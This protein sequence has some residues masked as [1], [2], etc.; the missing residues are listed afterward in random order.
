MLV[1]QRAPGFASSLLREIPVL[2][3][4]AAINQTVHREHLVANALAASNRDTAQRLGG[5][6]FRRPPLL[7][8]I[9][10]EVPLTVVDPGG[11]KKPDSF[12]RDVAE[13]YLRQAAVS[14]RPAQ[15]LAE[16]NGVPAATVHRWIREAKAAECC[17][18]QRTARRTDPSTHLATI[19]RQVPL[20]E[21]GIRVQPRT[22]RQGAPTSESRQRPQGPWRVSALLHRMPRSVRCPH[23]VVPR[24]TAARTRR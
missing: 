10:T 23:L 13:I 15:D 4:E 19:G 1:G 16:A 6:A 21:R 9:L 22:P 5:D 24:R 12:Y 7:K 8:P 17:T 3:I 14:A 2:R 18:C 20:Q 11:Y